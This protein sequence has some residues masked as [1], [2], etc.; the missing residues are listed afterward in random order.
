[1]TFVADSSSYWGASGVNIIGSGPAIF[2]LS[3]FKDVGKAVLGGGVDIP[4]FQSKRVIGSDTMGLVSVV[5]DQSDALL[6]ISVTTATFTGD[7]GSLVT[8]ATRNASIIAEVDYAGAGTFGIVYSQQRAQLFSY[9]INQDN[10]CII[11]ID[12][13]DWKTGNATILIPST[14]LPAIIF[15]SLSEFFVEATGEWYFLTA[16][17]DQ[18]TYKW[19]STVFSVNVDTMKVSQAVVLV[20]PSPQTEVL[21]VYVRAARWPTQDVVTPIRKEMSK[22]DSRIR[23]PMPRM[24]RRVVQTVSEATLS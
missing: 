4:A 24:T 9:R 13:L 2:I 18:Q 17:Q 5:A 6:F 14:A 23:R 10:D 11:G 3:I 7:L 16:L 21:A 15:R 8:Y 22:S 20:Y 19:T 12:A 1:V